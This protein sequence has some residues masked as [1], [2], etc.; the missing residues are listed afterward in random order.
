MKYKTKPCEINAMEWTGDN[1]QEILPVKKK[2]ISLHH[3]IL[4]RIQ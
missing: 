1:M 3:L 4:P 2:S